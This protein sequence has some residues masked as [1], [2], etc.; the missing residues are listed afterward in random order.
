MRRILRRIWQGFSL[1]FVLY[2]FYLF[3]LF[4]L[5]TFNRI[6]E[7]LALPASVVIT[8]IAMGISTLLWIRKHR[9]HLPVK[10]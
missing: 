8:L 1:L 10:L 5:D 2:G 4:V 6:N 3:F 9:E 7:D